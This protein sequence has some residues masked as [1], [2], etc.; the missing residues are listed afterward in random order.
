MQLHGLKDI[1]DWLRAEHGVEMAAEKLKALLGQ[2][3][4]EFVAAVRKLRGTRNKLTVAG[5]RNLKEEY[6]KFHA[7]HAE[8][9]AEALRLERQLGDLVNVAYGLSPEEVAL[10]W[11]TAPPRMPYGVE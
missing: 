9:V 6:A 5:L 10:M 7:P 4:G 11:R 8:A 3:E 2:G 1:L